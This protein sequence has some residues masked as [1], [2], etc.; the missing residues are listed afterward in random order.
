VIRFCPP[1]TVTMAEL[2]EGVFAVRKV[3]A[4]LAAK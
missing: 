1:L 4:E 3:A 2:D